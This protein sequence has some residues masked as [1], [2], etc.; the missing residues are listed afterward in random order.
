M[1]ALGAKLECVYLAHLAGAAPGAVP[2]NSTKAVPVSECARAIQTVG[3]E[4][5][6]ISSDLGQANNPVHTAGLRAFIAALQAEGVTEREIN[7]VARETPARLL[8]LAP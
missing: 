8:G 7:Q 1:A 3:A 5:F 4:N 2:T 6:L